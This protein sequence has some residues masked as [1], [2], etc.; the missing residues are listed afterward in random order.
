MYVTFL[1]GMPCVGIFNEILQNLNA[2]HTLAGSLSKTFGRFG[3]DGKNHWWLPSS[4]A[5]VIYEMT[6]KE[7]NLT[8]MCG[9][10]VD[11]VIIADNG[12]RTLVN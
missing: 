9:A 8:L 5:Q 6:N 12:N 3:F 11:D 2:N 1:C 4:F 7:K 10:R